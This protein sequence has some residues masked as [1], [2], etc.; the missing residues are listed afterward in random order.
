MGRVIVGFTGAFGSGTTF[1]KDHFFDGYKKFSLSKILK[2]LY[3]K[4]YKVAQEQTIKRC[5][6][7][8]YGNS[9]REQDSAFLAKEVDKEIQ[10]YPTDDIVIDSIRNPAEIKYFRDK[11][12]EFILI[13]VF[14]DYD[15]RWERVKKSYNESKDEFDRDEVKDK[16]SNEPDNGQ[17]ISD[18][19]FEADLIIKNNDDISVGNCEYKA[20]HDKLKAYIEDFKNPI[21]SKPTKNESLMA[22]AYI[23]GRDS[24]CYKRKVGAIIVDSMDQ[25]ISSGYNGTPVAFH[26]DANGK[27]VPNKIMECEDLYAK[28]YRDMQREKL[29]KEINTELQLESTEKT[30]AIIQKKIKL[31]DHCRALHGEERAILGLVG[32]GIDM[33]NSTMYVTTFPCNLCANKIVQV[34]IKKVI[35]FEPYPIEEAKKILT[36]GGVQYEPFEGVTFRAFFKFFQYEP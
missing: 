28:C 19:F 16:G 1:I 15:V 31:L 36:S 11:Y 27:N 8:D 26:K 6:L 33:E 25:I 34:G 22:A 32:K 24:R 35:Y 18:C 29:A 4:E 13:G 7:Q 30:P 14:A 21:K 2:D 17:K 3:I 9:K 12:T 23:S 10:K 5:Y 20:M